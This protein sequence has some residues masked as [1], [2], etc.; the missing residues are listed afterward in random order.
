MKNIIIKSAAII[1]LSVLAT[2][3]AMP[4]ATENMI[5]HP[6]ASKIPVSQKYKG[7]M[8]VRDV[9]GGEETNPLWTSQVDNASFK[10]ALEK[11]LAEI[12][13][14][15]PD[16]KKPRYFIDA[17]LRSLDQPFIG[18]D[19]DVSANVVY[20][21]EKNGVKTKYPINAVGTASVSD[22]FIAVERLKIANE[23]AIK[24]NI[25]YFFTT[26]AKPE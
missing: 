4:A 23:R 24:E 22:A 20:N 11:S 14:N 3:C 19:F 25:K 1:S 9:T 7:A 12:G 15:A 2:G 21:V 8:A 6:A 17:D 13:Y 10:E 26:I 16:G 18:L 5:I